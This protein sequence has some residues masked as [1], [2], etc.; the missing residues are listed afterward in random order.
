MDLTLSEIIDKILNDSSGYDYCG[1][2]IYVYCDIKDGL[3]C[4][5]FRYWDINDQEYSGYPEVYGKDEKDVL[6]KLYVKIKR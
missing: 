5:G 4:A 2:E 6:N 3:W 1:D